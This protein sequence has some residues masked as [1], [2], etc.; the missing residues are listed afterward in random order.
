[1]FSVPIRKYGNEIKARNYWNQVKE[2]KNK[3]LVHNLDRYVKVTF[4]V[5]MR[6]FTELIFNY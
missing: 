5:Q 1:M 6:I 2:I 3:L 4:I